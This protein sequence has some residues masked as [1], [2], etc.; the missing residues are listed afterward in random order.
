MNQF[1]PTIILITIILIALVVATAAATCLCG[2][3]EWKLPGVG[4]LFWFAAILLPLLLATW[5]K[6]WGFVVALAIYVVVVIAPAGVITMMNLF[7]IKRKE[8]SRR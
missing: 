5:A 3:P 6:G 2:A 1:A 4:V 7:D 8:T